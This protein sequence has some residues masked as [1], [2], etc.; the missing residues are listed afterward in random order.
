MLGSLRTKRPDGDHRYGRCECPSNRTPA[1]HKK[2]SQADKDTILG[3]FCRYFNAH[4]L[5]PDRNGI[6]RSPADIHSECISEAYT[7]CKARGFFRLWAY[8]FNNWYS[9]VCARLVYF[10]CHSIP[11]GTVLLTS[12]LQWNRICAIHHGVAD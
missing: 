6:F 2:L 11:N 8:L 9:Q 1:E 4:S 12:I 7:W 5:I 10:L 3:T